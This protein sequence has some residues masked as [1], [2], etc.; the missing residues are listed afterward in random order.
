MVNITE[1]IADLDDR[2]WMTNKTLRFQYQMV[3][4]LEHQLEEKEKEGQ[5]KKGRN[6]YQAD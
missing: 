4:A 6:K 3:T 2:I 1:T 5:C